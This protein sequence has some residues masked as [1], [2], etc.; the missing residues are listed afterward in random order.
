MSNVCSSLRS[1]PPIRCSLEL[2]SIRLSR[3]N[4]PLEESSVAPFQFNVGR[5]A[6]HIHPADLEDSDQER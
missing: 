3:Q 2:H 1:C 5:I 4:A 6:T